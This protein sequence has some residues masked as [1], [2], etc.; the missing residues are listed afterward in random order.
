MIWPHVD[1]A[2]PVASGGRLRFITHQSDLGHWRVAAGAPAPPL[3]GYVRGYWGYSDN[4]L[5]VTRRRKAPSG[6]VTLIVNFGSPFR[7]TDTRRPECRIEPPMHFVAGLHDCPIDIEA[8]GDSHCL[9]VDFTPIGA[10]HFLRQPMHALTDRTVAFDD[11]LGA[12]AVRLRAAL[13]GA[14]DWASRFALLDAAIATRLADR[15]DGPSL[16]TQAWRMLHGRDGR[17]DVG[18]LCA[19]LG[20]TRQ[21]LIA[22]FHR[23]IGLPPK[24]LARIMRVNRALRRLERGTPTNWADLAAE[25]GFYDQ[26]HLIHDVRRLAGVAPSTY[27][28]LRL[29]DLGGVAVP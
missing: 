21:Q 29:P 6:F 11:L 27:L 24:R 7:L 26:S 8:T 13:A 18:S 17:M 2:S 23:E 3:A 4:G 14:A 9:Q 1:D 20:C 25:C 10:Y 5:R 22:G 28:R 16:A 19:K 12:S 15:V